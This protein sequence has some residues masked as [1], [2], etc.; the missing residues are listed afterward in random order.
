MLQDI[1]VLAPLD[2][3][4]NLSRH[5]QSPGL[6]HGQHGS[7]GPTQVPLNNALDDPL[8]FPFGCSAMVI[9]IDSVAG[10]RSLRRNTCLAEA[11]RRAE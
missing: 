9:V 7:R 4:A 11:E 5:T 1:E 8:G 10:A 3:R 6:E 2:S